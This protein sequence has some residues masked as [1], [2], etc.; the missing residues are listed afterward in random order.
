MVIRNFLTIMQNT[1]STIVKTFR[2]DNGHEFFSSDFKALVSSLGIIH[3]SSCVY[4]PQQ[5]GVVE[6][7]YRTILEI[8][9]SLRFQEAVP[10]KFWGECVSTTVYLINM[11]PSR[12][13]HNKSPFEMLQLH[14]PSL[15]HLRVFECL[16]YASNP[17]KND[18]FAPI[19]L[20][21]I[22]LGYSSTQKGYKIYS[23]HTKSLFESRHVVL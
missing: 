23:L 2:T 18:K 13:L 12:V 11:L 14:P 22:L 1:F 5:N 4:A 21:V 6:R 15:I 16:C 17:K 19:A 3:Q 8:A 10:L 20:P 7:K 9:R